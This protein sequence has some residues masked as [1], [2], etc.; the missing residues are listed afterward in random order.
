MMDDL[1]SRQAA[2]DAVSEACG[3]WLGIFRDCKDALKAVPTAEPRTIIKCDECKYWD[4]EWIP[5]I[6]EGHYCPMMDHVMVGD[7][8]CCYAERRSDG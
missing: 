2:I 6:G 4:T 5:A 8:W 7:E 1:I 3:D